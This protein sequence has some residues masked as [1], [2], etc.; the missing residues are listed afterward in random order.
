MKV[1]KLLRLHKWGCNVPII[2][3]NPSRR[4][5]STAWAFMSGEFKK[6]NLAMVVAERDGRHLH[7]PP[8]SLQGALLTCSQLE[9]NGWRV[10]VVEWSKPE[11]EGS[12]LLREDEGVLIVKPKYRERFTFIDLIK[13]PKHR[14]IVR[15]I[16]MQ[17]RRHIRRD[18]TVSFY[19]ATDFMGIN[20]SKLVI[21]D[22]NFPGDALT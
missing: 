7:I 18:V 3:E 15:E 20:F 11:F 22:Y 1:A 10:L 14:H 2:V 16:K 12:V 5:E 6:K 17:I 13:S 4:F 9:P 8:Q 21:S 19:W